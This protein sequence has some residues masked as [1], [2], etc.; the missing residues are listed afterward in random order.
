MNSNTFLGPIVDKLA[1]QLGLPP[2]I[3]QMVVSFI[4]N[5]MMAGAAGG[6]VTPSQGTPS[7]VFPSQR[8]SQQPAQAQQGLDLDDLLGQVSAGQTLN[9]GYLNRTG[10]TNELSLQTGMDTNTA[11]MSLQEA[12]KLL[13]GA[14]GSFQQTEQTT[15]TSSKRSTAQGT[16]PKTSRSTKTTSRKRSTPKRSGSGGSGM[17]S[18]LDEFKIQ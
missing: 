18:L 16:R 15:R 1:E 11:V 13:D 14:L 10:M 7:Q 5:K 9:T 6:A 17:D 3:A 8:P 2:A 4:L 12:F